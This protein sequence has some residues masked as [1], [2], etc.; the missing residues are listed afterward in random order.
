MIEPC[1]RPTRSDTHSSCSCR[2]EKPFLLAVWLPKMQICHIDCGEAITLQTSAW[3]SNLSHK[4]LL[5][6]NHLFLSAL[7]FLVS[8]RPLSATHRL[9]CHSCRTMTYCLNRHA[10]Q[11]DP[12]QA[13]GNRVVYL[14]RPRNL[15]ERGRKH[16]GKRLRHFIFSYGR[17]AYCHL[18]RRNRR[19]TQEIQPNEEELVE[20]TGCESEAAS[21]LI[22][23]N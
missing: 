2:I 8:I 10:W 23:A 15:H 22:S 14:I 12:Y 6:T 16:Q 21:P 4:F 3:H 9:A 1:Q 19:D 18:A 11:T 7:A 5:K 20:S 13:K 17:R